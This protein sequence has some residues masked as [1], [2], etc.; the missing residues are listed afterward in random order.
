MPNDDV[1]PPQ[2][3]K[4]R[5]TW[6]I[7]TIVGGAAA[8][9]AI[10]GIGGIIAVAKRN[11][12]DGRPP[13]ALAPVDQLRSHL[14]VQ[15]KPA[16]VCE[17]AS[18]MTHATATVACTWP[19]PHVPQTATYSLYDDSTAMHRSALTLVRGSGGYGPSCESADDFSGDGGQMQWQRDDR[20]RGTMWC[21]LNRNGEPVILWTDTA[22]KILG[23][24]VAPTQDQAGQLLDWFH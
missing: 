20:E 10:A 11:A 16:D 18:P 13:V 3:P 7:W 5:P 8:L 22:P 15:L 24:A 9:I 21:Y 6:L 12:S 19:R 14:P 2:S 1:P 23:S 4:Q 17:E